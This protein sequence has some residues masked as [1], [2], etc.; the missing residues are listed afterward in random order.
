MSLAFSTTPRRRVAVI[1][2]AC[3]GS[4]L[5]LAGAS[6]FLMVGSSTRRKGLPFRYEKANFPF[7]SS[8]RE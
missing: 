6:T 7:R 8:L 2:S 5:A 4:G 3:F 1:V